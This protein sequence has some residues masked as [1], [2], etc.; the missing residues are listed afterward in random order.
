MYTVVTVHTVHVHVLT[1]TLSTSGCPS[2]SVTLIKD[3][4]DTVL[5]VLVHGN[6]SLRPEAEPSDQCM[7]PM[8]LSVSII[9]SQFGRRP[10][11]VVKGI[12]SGV[13]QTRPKEGG[14]ESIVIPCDVT[15]VL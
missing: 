7:L 12:V 4:S 9:R 11:V 10:C 6:T 5:L 13:S 14:V 1:N 15:I 8:L 3:D 2:T